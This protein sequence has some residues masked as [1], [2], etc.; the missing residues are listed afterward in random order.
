DKD[1]RILCQGDFEIFTGNLLIV[2]KALRNC[3]T[4]VKSL[5]FVNAFMDIAIF[6]LE[7]TFLFHKFHV[8]GYFRLSLVVICLINADKKI[9]DTYNSCL[10]PKFQ[11]A[12]KRLNWELKPKAQFVLDM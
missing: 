1:K 11:N 3:D 5:E 4:F 2:W 7:T 9:Y 12:L 6:Y 10:A 8:I